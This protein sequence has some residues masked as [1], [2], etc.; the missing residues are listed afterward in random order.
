[1]APPYVKRLTSGCVAY[2]P[3]TRKLGL[4]R[5]ITVSVWADNEIA[6]AAFAREKG[7]DWEDMGIV[8]TTEAAKEL[9]ETLLHAVSVLEDDMP[10]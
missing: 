1:M 7:V 5:S 3:P 10:R 9:A 2:S 4:G 6:I 8:L